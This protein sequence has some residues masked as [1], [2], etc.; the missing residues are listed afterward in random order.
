MFSYARAGRSASIGRDLERG[1][2]LAE[3]ADASTVAGRAQ[4][5]AA[6]EREGTFGNAVITAE[7]RYSLLTKHYH[8]T[9]VFITPPQSTSTFYP[10]RADPT[11]H[12]SRTEVISKVTKRTILRVLIFQIAP[13][14]E[15]GGDR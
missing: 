12:E 14:S 4:R 9:H 15:K 3:R 11:H 13:R 5:G 1:R 7:V 10:L 8:T 6:R 2:P